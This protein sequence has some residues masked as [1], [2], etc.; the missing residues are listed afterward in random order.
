MTKPYDRK[1]FYIERVR[2]DARWRDLQQSRPIQSKLEYM[3]GVA[4]VVASI[5]AML[6]V[7]SRFF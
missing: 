7:A 1:D 2:S 6:Y 5:F 4:L 3:S